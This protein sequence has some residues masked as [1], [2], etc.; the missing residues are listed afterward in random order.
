MWKIF[1]EK[2]VISE[3][4]LVPIPS[5]MPLREAALM[6]CAIPTGAGILINNTKVKVGD[7]VA[8]FG[9][10]GIGLSVVMVASIIGAKKI[11]AIDIEEKKLELSKQIGATHTINSSK[12]DPLVKIRD[13]TLNN[14]VDVAIEAAGKRVTMEKAFQSYKFRKRC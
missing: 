14:G 12:H 9:V 2:T 10:G 11:I 13:I 3:N 5:E 4:R 8:V 1:M 7:T 6:G